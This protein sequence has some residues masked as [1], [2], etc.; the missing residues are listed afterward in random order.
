MVCN[1]VMGHTTEAAIVGVGLKAGF[2][3]LADQYV[4]SEDKAFS[5]EH[6]WVTVRFSEVEINFYYYIVMLLV[7]A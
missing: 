2:Q 5:S 3:G 6:K 4:R 7:V 1:D